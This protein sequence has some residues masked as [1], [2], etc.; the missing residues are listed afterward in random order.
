MIIKILHVHC[1]RSQEELMVIQDSSVFKNSFSLNF[2]LQY[3]C[4]LI[5]MKCLSPYKTKTLIRFVTDCLQAEIYMS[6]CQIFRGYSKQ[7]QTI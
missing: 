3:T 7:T 4:I 2:F 5:Q 6:I 1:I